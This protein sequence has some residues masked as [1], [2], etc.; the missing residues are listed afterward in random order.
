MYIKKKYTYMYQKWKMAR[1][2]KL[3]QN[4]VQSRQIEMIR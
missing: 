2:E 3:S 1:E 4:G